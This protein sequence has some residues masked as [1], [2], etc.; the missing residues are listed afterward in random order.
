MLN[1]V[2]ATKAH[3]DQTWTK[4]GIRLPVTVVN[5]FP[6]TVTQIKTQDTD[7]YQAIQI[8]FKGK[9]RE[10][11]LASI[12]ELKV[13][14]IVNPFDV[15]AEKDL[16]KV[17]GKSKGKGFT[18]VVKRWGFKGGSRTHGQSDRQRAPGSIGQGTDPG[19]VHKGKKMP[20]RAGGQTITVKNLPVIKVDP[21]LNQ[22]WLKGQIPGPRH[23]LLTITKLNKFV[24]TK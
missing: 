11:R 2:F 3:Q 5:P 13:G 6:M 17:T 23:N 12:P 8:S 20:G 4:S 1:T 9:K 22:I 10:V 24:S 7:G 18:G 14:D 15:L 19:R 21:E 16:V